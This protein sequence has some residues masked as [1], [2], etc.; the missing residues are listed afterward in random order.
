MIPSTS[1]TL[2]RQIGGDARH[3]RWAE[4]VAR[5]SPACRQYLRRHFP[6]LEADDILQETFAALAKALPDYRYDPQEKGYFRNYL[7]GILRNKALMALRKRRRDEEVLADYA[8]MEK[9]SLLGGTRSGASAAADWQK[10]V[11]EIALQQLM[12]DPSIHDRTKQIFVRTAI[13]QESPA[14]VA[15][16]LG[17]SRN[18]V[19]QQKR[20]TLVKFKALVAA[21]R[22]VV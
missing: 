9:S 10:S 17:V 14:A 8:D 4:F 19:D 13:R 3:A 5:Y 7:A 16:A 20:R 21:L 15:A 2:L 12:S 22:G 11:F 18:V 1:T 6:S